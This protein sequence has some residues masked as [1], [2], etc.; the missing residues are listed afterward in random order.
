MG[1]TTT[2]PYLIRKDRLIDMLDPVATM[3]IRNEDIAE[4]TYIEA[5]CGDERV[6]IA[7]CRGSVS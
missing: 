1:Q 3:K 5:T 2:A 4:A 7:G 6:G